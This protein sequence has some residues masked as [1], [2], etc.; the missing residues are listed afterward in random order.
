MKTIDDLI[1]NT[2]K[3][4]HKQIIE[5]VLTAI[6][7]KSSKYILKGGTS[8][9]ECYGLSRFSEDIDLDSTDKETIDQIVAEYANSRG[10]TYRIAKNTDTVKRFM[11]DYGGKNEFGDK[12]LKIEISYRRKNIPDQEVTNI[13]N[14]AVYTL[15]NI[16]TMKANE[17]A[18]RDKIRDLYDI[19][20]LINEKYDVL[21]PYVCVI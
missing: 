13:N 18:S 9:M 21:N 10:Y 15:D 4:K 11:L 6:N 20:F 8:L 5:D 14:I 2:W 16:A 12:P 19:V 17:Y 1:K 7:A 3:E